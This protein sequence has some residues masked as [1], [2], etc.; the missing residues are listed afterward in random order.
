MCGIIH[1]RVEVIFQRLGIVLD[2]LQVSIRLVA[3]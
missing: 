2:P 3:A 1:M